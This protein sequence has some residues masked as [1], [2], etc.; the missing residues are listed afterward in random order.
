MAMMTVG[1]QLAEE[2]IPDDMR[3]REYNARA[4]NTLDENFYEGYWGKPIITFS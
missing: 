4:R 1:Y 2:V 3:E